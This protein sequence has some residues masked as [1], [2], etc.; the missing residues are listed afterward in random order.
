MTVSAA[1]L[2]V[3][4]ALAS[5]LAVGGLRG[6]LL[7]R[8]M[9]DVP[10][11][12]S[13]HEVPTPRGAGL[14]LAAVA[15]AAAAACALTP[16]WRVPLAWTWIAIGGGCAALGW[17]DDLRSRSARL[18]LAV[19]CALAGV[20]AVAIAPAAGFTALDAGACVLRLLG[21][22][23][24]VNLYNFMDGADGFAGVQAIAVMLCAAALLAHGGASGEAVRALLVAGAALGFL[25]WNWPPA[26]IFLGDSGSYFLGFACGAGALGGGG[27]ALGAAP[28]LILMAP[29][30][31]DA[32]LTLAG[33]ALRGAPLFEAHR[34]H[35]YQRL[36][37]G[38]WSRHRLLAALVA[39]HVLVLWPAAWIAA[40][41]GGWAWLAVAV[42]YG[43]A[44]M[45]WR[46]G[47]RLRRQ[48]PAAARR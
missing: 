43:V 10:N 28:W 26:R 33:R 34:E 20:F 48:D 24:L 30:V 47:A 46:H 39:M 37:L 13:M 1:A 42:V 3:A 41:A 38:G 40:G 11:G 25:A 23:W 36:L 22:V 21:L 44:A 32:T 45:M 19:Q 9:V 16:A 8:A 35:V 12:R 7:R 29:F 6:W 31:T 2:L 27:S 4:T 18:R 17:A 15:L 5:A 14:A